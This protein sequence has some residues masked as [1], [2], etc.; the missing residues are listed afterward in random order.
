MSAE[1]TAY[2]LKKA[3]SQGLTNCYTEESCEDVRFSGRS[4]LMGK[5]KPQITFMILTYPDTETA[6][7]AFKPVWK[8]WSS[9]VPDGKTLD[10]GDIGEQSSAVSGADVSFAPGSKRIL[11]QV[12][13][14][15]VILLT[16]GAS[17]PKVGLQNSLIAKFATMFAER[18]RQAREG[19]TPS[20][21]LA[22]A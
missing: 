7:S 21:T 1:P 2:P 4:V 10:L 3:V 16:H 15:S 18:A 22:D 9:R 8:A 11:S 14:G 19:E 6:K 17:A 20:A 12:R 5:K 13:V